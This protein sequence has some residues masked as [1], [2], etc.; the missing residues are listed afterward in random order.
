MR[1]EREQL[2]TG[3]AVHDD[4]VMVPLRPWEKE[5]RAV[6]EQCTDV[7]TVTVVLAN[8][9]AVA[10]H[11]ATERRACHTSVFAD[12]DDTNAAT[13]DDP[14]AKMSRDTDDGEASGSGTPPVIYNL[15]FDDEAY[16]VLSSN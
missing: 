2:D 8:P 11:H 15:S 14:M 10:G 13:A 9:Q 12:L 1:R 4:C 6:E 7:A 5:H 3:A 16:L